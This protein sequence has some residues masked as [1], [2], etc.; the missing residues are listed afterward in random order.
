MHVFLVY[1][2]I[3]HNLNTSNC[4]STSYALV[5]QP[6]NLFAQIHVR[7]AYLFSKTLLAF[8]LIESWDG[9]RWRVFARNIF[10]TTSSFRF[11]LRREFQEFTS[12]LGRLLF[13]HF[14]SMS[15]KW[16]PRRGDLLFESWMKNIFLSPADVSSWQSIR[17][18][19]NWFVYLSLSC[20]F[21][22]QNRINV[23]HQS[24]TVMTWCS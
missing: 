3:I 16:D 10:L 4:Y 14:L 11:S 5:P 6:C 13:W 9:V 8:R 20:R 1:N 19:G 15:N 17:E 22:H 18:W 23:L 7:I 21:P 2:P 24:D 12:C